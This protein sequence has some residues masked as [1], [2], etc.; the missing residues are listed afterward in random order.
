MFLLK[1]IAI[2]IQTANTLGA[3]DDEN[4]S[5]S[6]SESDGGMDEKVKQIMREANGEV[7]RKE[8]GPLKGSDIL[9]VIS[10]LVTLHGG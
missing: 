9:K 4:T 5:G 6:E 10:D 2:T 1:E 3:E 8:L 7:V